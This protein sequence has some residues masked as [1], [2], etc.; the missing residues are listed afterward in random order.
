MDNRRLD[1][2]Y[3]V[4]A[5]YL[6]LISMYVS[7]ASEQYDETINKVIRIEEKVAEINNSIVRINEIASD[8]DAKINEINDTLIDTIDEQIEK[9]SNENS[10]EVENVSKDNN[11]TSNNIPNTPSYDITIEEGVLT[12]SKGV[13]WFEGHKE[14]YYNLNMSRVVENAHNNGIDGEYWIR[15]DGCKMLGDYIMVA[16]GYSIHPYGSIVGTSLGT[17]IVV[18]TGGFA[19]SDP[20]LVDIAVDW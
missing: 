20:Y 1:F 11:V 17:G 2:L 18:D 14:T 13:N 9:Y 3:I 8:T 5:I 4:F 7:L 12:P 6:I 15:S 16:A 10:I 19:S